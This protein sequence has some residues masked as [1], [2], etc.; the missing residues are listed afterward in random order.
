MKKDR[1]TF[2]G[3][4]SMSTFS[5]QIQPQFASPYNYPINMPMGQAQYTQQ[6]F[7][8]GAYPTMN[9]PVMNNA[10]ATDYSDLESRMAKMERQM[11]RLEQRIQ[12]LESQTLSSHNDYE[13]NQNS[14]NN[15]MYMI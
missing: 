6:S 4:A 8:T 9:I 1:N 10:M 5:N 15:N 3:E 11:N 7:S 14:N 12:K 2:F 13:I